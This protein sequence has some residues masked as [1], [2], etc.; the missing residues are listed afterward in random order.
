MWQS[1]TTY[2]ILTKYMTFLKTIKLKKLL[3]FVDFYKM[4]ND[5]D[6]DESSIL[7][8]FFKDCL[9][10]KKL[11]RIKDVIYDK[12]NGEIKSIPALTYIKTNKHFTIK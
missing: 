9:D 7:V 3:E 1:V 4:D 12:E 8:Q 10:R 5:L 2:N 6:E 11:L